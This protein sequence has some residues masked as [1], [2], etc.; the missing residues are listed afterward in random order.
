MGLSRGD[1]PFSSRLL[2]FNP[3]EMPTPANQQVWY[4]GFLKPFLVAHDL[5]R[6]TSFFLEELNNST[7]ESSLRGHTGIV[8]QRVGSN[9]CEPSPRV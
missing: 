9:R 7:D 4:A 5:E 1:I 3:D 8:S 2:D 6:A